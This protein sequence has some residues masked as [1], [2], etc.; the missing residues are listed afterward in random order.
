MKQLSALILI[1]TSYNSWGALHPDLVAPATN[2]GISGISGLYR[3]PVDND[4]QGQ[5]K[6]STLLDTNMPQGSFEAWHRGQNI[7]TSAI[8]DAGGEMPGGGITLG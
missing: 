7:I 8:S 6:A 4:V 2:T 1:F 3:F 5:G